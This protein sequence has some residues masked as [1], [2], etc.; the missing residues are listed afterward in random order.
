MFKNRI[1]NLNLF[2]LLILLLISSLFYKKLDEDLYFDKEIWAYSL[3]NS[4]PNQHYSFLN[5][6]LVINNYGSESLSGYDENKL[7]IARDTLNSNTKGPVLFP[8][9]LKM[10]W[11]CYEDKSFY[12]IDEKLPYELIQ[13]KAKELKSRISIETEIFPNGK[14]SFNVISATN[15]IKQNITPFLTF[16]AKKSNENWEILKRNDS[17]FDDITTLSDYILFF[18]EMPTWGIIVEMPDNASF[19]AAFAADFY[20]NDLKINEISHDIISSKELKLPRSIQIQWFEQRGYRCDFSMDAADFLSAY[21]ELQKT[22]KS[23]DFN[24]VFHVSKQDNIFE[25][26]IQNDK[27]R[28]QLKND[29]SYSDIQDN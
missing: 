15:N 10:S 23:K 9:S 3:K 11:F 16:Q 19:N 14:V 24:F 22:S 1:N 8:D 26:Y 28:I 25:V 17:S 20:G 21:L 27:K 6:G 5:F 12:K 2:L 13:K 18:S 4:S 7:L 29:S